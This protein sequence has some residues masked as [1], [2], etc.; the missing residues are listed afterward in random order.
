MGLTARAWSRTFGDETHRFRL[1]TARQVLA[2]TKQVDDNDRRQ[3]EELGDRYGCRDPK[4]T[5]MMSFHP[6]VLVN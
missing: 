2:A 6:V 3:I 1:P 4:D 5:I